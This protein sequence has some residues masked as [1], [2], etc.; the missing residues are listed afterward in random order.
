VDAQWIVPHF[1]KMSYDNAELLKAYLDGYTAQGE[2]Y[3]AET[4]RGIVRWV[5]EVLADPE[6]GYGA[7]QDADVG[8]NDDGDYFTWTVEEARSAIGDEDAFA[9]A[10]AYYDIGTA[11]EM[12]HDPAKNVLYTPEPLPGIATRLGVDPDAAA[13]RLVL[14]KTR[15]QAARAARPAP[16]V[17]RARYTGW[18]GML[19]GA[20]IRAGVVL[21]DPW[22]LQHGLL[23]LRRIRR[24]HDDP[25]RLRH[26]PGG[27]GGLLDD[28]V[29]VALAVI[30]AHEAT[31][32]EE[33]L[34]WAVAL[35]DRVWD[36][37]L[38]P[39]GGGLFDSSAPAGEGLLPTRIKPVQ[40]A[41]TPSPNGV[42]ALG[43]ARLAELTGAGRWLERRDALLR[44]FAGSAVQLGLHGA[45][46]LLA[47]DWAV[48]PA[49]HV[50][51]V[52]GDGSGALA[53]EMH[54][55]A[56]RAFLPRRVVQRVRAGDAD[57]TPLPPAVAG[58]LAN[59]GGTRG[60]ACIGTRCLAPATDPSEWAATLGELVKLH[61]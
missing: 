5:R 4:A 29:Q 2:E 16:F 9:V 20:L 13:A 57:T 61:R 8:L 21:D 22:A 6:G 46:Y 52:T 58:M 34:G 37:Y 42:A 11:G 39:A 41:P 50:V 3:L 25:T 38:D 49:T 15:M 28:Q 31:G 54:R 36:E 59:G 19:A 35:L 44:A 17:D 47:L 32:D 33:W 14:A 48:H 24:E 26:S 30:D 10:A 60:Y 27:V 40:D 7:S 55:M 51:I 43:A 23:T 56:L 45:T 12:H 1:E 18:N 53:D